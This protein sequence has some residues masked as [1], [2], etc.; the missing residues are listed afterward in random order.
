MQNHPTIQSIGELHLGKLSVQEQL[1]VISKLILK[2][3]ELRHS[4]KLHMKILKVQLEIDNTPTKGTKMNWNDMQSI[5]DLGERTL[6]AKKPIIYFLDPSIFDSNILYPLFEKITKIFNERETIGGSPGKFLN[7]MNEK[8]NIIEL[9]EATL[10]ENENVITLY[11][12]KLGV[13]PSLLLY[14]TSALIQPLLEEIARTIDPSFYDKWWQASCPICGRIPNVAR[15]RQ[16]KRYLVCT[17][18]GAEYLYDN[19][20]C[21][22]CNNKDPYSLKFL[23]IDGKPE[24]QV[25]FCTKC[26]HY[27][28]VINEE[29]LKDTIP[30]GLE[31]MITL[32]LDL[33]AKG[34]GLVRL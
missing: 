21:V 3:K 2:R 34:E 31:D 19:F 10:R 7:L 17:F 12:E 1:N 28:K 29:P 13:Q 6:K 8:I 23:T 32:D 27:I 15:L 18:C 16:R 22:H 14:I 30:K 25:D 9:I 26:K 24:F 5:L 33:V 20:T 4:L 11:A